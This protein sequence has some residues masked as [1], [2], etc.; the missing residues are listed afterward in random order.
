MTQT[1]KI[2]YLEDERIKI[3]RGQ[4]KGVIPVH[5]FGA[6][7]TMST[8]TTGTVWDKND[9]IYPWSA[10]SRNATGAGPTPYRG[11]RCVLLSRRTIS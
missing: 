10:C 6:V 2:S 7:P 11:V 9:T 1:N 3:S 5:K 4:V 8:N